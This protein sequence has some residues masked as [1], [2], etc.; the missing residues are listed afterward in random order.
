MLKQ[1]LFRLY[2][3]VGSQKFKKLEP[4]FNSKEVL[5]YLNNLDWSKPWASGA[6]FSSICVYSATQESYDSKLLKEFIDNLVD[7]ESGFYFRDKPYRQRQLFNGA[8]KIISGLDWINHDIHYPEKIID[9]CIKISQYLRAVILLII[10]TLYM[11]SKKL[12][13][14]KKKL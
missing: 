6:Q 4:E 7:V 8:M 12:I 9:F 14:R 13:T 3:Q 10:F 2:Y 11:C 5:N 1:R